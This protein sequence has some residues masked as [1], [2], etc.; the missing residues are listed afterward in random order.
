MTW[1]LASCDRSGFVGL[2]VGAPVKHEESDQV[3]LG[4]R[5]LER[6][7]HVSHGT[8]TQG[9]G[10][11]MRTNYRGAKPRNDTDEKQ[12]DSRATEDTAVVAA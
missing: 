9:E 3:C 11:T 1:L 12:M 4:G 7:S 10:N 8:V 2:T 5:W 6:C